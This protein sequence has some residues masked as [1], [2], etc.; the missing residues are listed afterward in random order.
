[1]GNPFAISSSAYLRL[2]A[3]AVAAA[4]ATGSSVVTEQ[5]AV[6]IGALEA[7]YQSVLAPPHSSPDG[8]ASIEGHW[9]P[10]VLAPYDGRGTLFSWRLIETE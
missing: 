5:L 1:M 3:A 8:G 9:T 7:E 2:F 6:S 10:P 4:R